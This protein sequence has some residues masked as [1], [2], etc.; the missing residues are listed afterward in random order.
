MAAVWL[1]MAL[2]AGEALGL[3]QDELARGES[4]VRELGEVDHGAVSLSAEDTDGKYHKLKGGDL[5]AYAV[6]LKTIHGGHDECKAACDKDDACEGY[7]FTSAKIGKGLCKLL[8]HKDSFRGRVGKKAE[9][10][11]VKEVKVKMKTTVAQA[12]IKTAKV[13]VSLRKEETALQAARRKTELVKQKSKVEAQTIASKISE[14]RVA[15]VALTKKKAALETQLENQ[16]EVEKNAA[17][18]SKAKIQSAKSMESSV[19]A[20]RATLTEAVK[21][22]VKKGLSDQLDS[23]KAALKAKMAGLKKIAQNEL[24][25]AREEYE[26]LSEKADRFKVAYEKLKARGPKKMVLPP[27]ATPINIKKEAEKIQVTKSNPIVQA[28]I[29]KA[30]KKADKKAKNQEFMAKTAGVKNTGPPK[31][32]LKKQE[33]KKAEEQAMVVVEGQKAEVKNIA[34][35]AEKTLKE[36]SNDPQVKSALKEVIEEAAT[37]VAETASK[38]ALDEIEIESERKMTNIVAEKEEREAEEI[39][40]DKAD[41]AAKFAK[42][43]K[44]TEGA[45][46][47]WLAKTLAKFTPKDQTKYFKALK[48]LSM[49]ITKEFPSAD[50]LTILDTEANNFIAKERKK[51]YRAEQKKK[52]VEVAAIRSGGN[53]TLAGVEMQKIANQTKEL[54]A[55]RNEGKESAELVNAV[56]KADA[57]LEMH[58]AKKDL[59]KVEQKLNLAKAETKVVDQEKRVEDKK[60]QDMEAKVKALEE[61]KDKG[62]PPTKVTDTVDK[63]GKII[64]QTTKVSKPDVKAQEAAQVVKD[65]IKEG[66]VLAKD[67]TKKVAKKQDAKSGKN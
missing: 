20:K 49:K 65:K 34:E 33:E 38:K 39:K 3:P 50:R 42:R 17:A 28:A 61:L 55:E 8:A 59:K 30:D 10:E 26:S 4:R 46:K 56:K 51:T 6:V 36:S 24:K 18:T 45:Q 43:I 22:K 23:R 35:K 27:V 14:I 41:R 12:A 16:K 64:A 66:D 5:P 62:E 19:L 40:N 57:K 48:L 54:R 63:T 13:A 37:K 11:V 53:A 9:G 67:A 44:A 32:V 25:Q 2:T 60:V 21:D 47:E 7:K 29:A 52:E 1:V 31:A 15:S 58:K